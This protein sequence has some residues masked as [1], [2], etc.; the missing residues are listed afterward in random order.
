[1]AVRG[2][3]RG[4]IVAKSNPGGEE[5]VAEMLAESDRAKSSRLAAGGRRSYWVLSGVPNHRFATDEDFE[6][7]S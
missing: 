4:V 1:V 7:G 3:K 2:V 6:P 5:K